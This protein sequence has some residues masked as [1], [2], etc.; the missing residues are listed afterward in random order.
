MLKSLGKPITSTVIMSL[1]VLLNIALSLLF[2][3]K[4]QWGVM[5][6]SI[7]TGI[8]F[9]IAAFISG[10]ILIAGRHSVSLLKGR[11]SFPLLWRASYNGS[12][13][14]ASELSSA[15]SILIINNIIIRIMGAD[16]VSAF[17]VLSYTNFIGILLFL[18]I[19]DG[20]IPVMGYV[21]GAKQF[22]RLKAFFN[23]IAKTNLL[24]GIAVFAVLQYFGTEI[25]GLFL[26]DIHSHVAIIAHQGLRI[27]SFV[28]LVNGFNILVTSFFTAIGNALG[29]IIVASLRGVIFIGIGML[30]LPSWLGEKGIWITLALSEYLTL[31]VTVLLY[32]NKM[33]TLAI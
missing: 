24:I 30:I 11:F 22:T 13:E 16:G 31:V 19:S 15:V 14:G 12:S 28:F 29:S 20:M 21:F 18:G 8:A 3:L 6:T 7:A 27:F 4:L 1:V 32:R 26:K 17:T 10:A 9:T 23:F 33:K 2:V 25:I 5:G